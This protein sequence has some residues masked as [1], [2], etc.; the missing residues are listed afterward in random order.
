M[1]WMVFVCCTQEKNTSAAPLKEHQTIQ[2]KGTFVA[3]QKYASK[4]IFSYCI[5]Q[6]AE[7]LETVKD[8]HYYCPMTQEWEEA[9]R[10]VWGAKLV[11][12]G[13]ELNSFMLEAVQR[14]H[15]K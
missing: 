3:C 4:D 2:L 12:R 11:R 15:S 1:W 5:Y 10:H 13:R 9:C 14:M 8:V 7:H 6:K